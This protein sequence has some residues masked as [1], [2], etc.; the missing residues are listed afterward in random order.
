M[1]ME[2]KISV[3]PTPNPNALKFVLNVPAKSRES[4]VFKSSESEAPS[5]PL[6]AELLKLPS[7]IEVYFSGYFITVTQSGSADWDALEKQVKAVIF[8]NIQKHDPDFEVKRQS[9]SVPRKPSGEIAKIE[10][11]LD[12]TIRP[13]LQRDGGDLQV[14]SLEDKVLTISYQGACGCCP[15]AAMGTLY[16]IQNILRD[17]YDP[18]LQV[19]MA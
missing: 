15:H 18:A 4:A 17:Q 2:Y 9:Y 12:R 6:A 16:A 8:D 13:A 7:V 3:Q 5:V 1:Q 10:D 14:I 19:E 11:I